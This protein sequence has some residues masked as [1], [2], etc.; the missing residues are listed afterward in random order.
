MSSAKEH[1]NSIENSGLAIATYPKGF[2][3]THVW[4]GLHLQEFVPHS[5][6]GGATAWNKSEVRLH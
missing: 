4:L 2:Q 3:E 5:G 1:V 6:V